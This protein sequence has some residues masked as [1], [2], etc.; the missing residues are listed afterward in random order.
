MKY[1]IDLVMWDLDGTLLDTKPGIIQA[2]KETLEL[3]ELRELTDEELETFIGPP[4]GQSFPRFYGDDKQEL[5]EFV[6]IFRYIYKNKTFYY[7]EPFDG[8]V[9]VMRTLRKNGIKQTL[10]TYKLQNYA[11][12]LMEH[13]KLDEFLN[14]IFG[15]LLTESLLKSDM[16]INSAK[17][18]HINDMKRTV[19]IGDTR[20][21]YSAAILANAN[22]IAANYGYGEKI[23]KEANYGG[24]LL[25]HANTAYEILDY[26]N[27]K[28]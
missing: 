1:D 8:I 27:I 24:T 17:Y 6:E 4:F 14:C 26:I 3:M 21:D 15:S 19:L 20:Y 11:M 12:D 25:G 10:C 2:I 22:F 16:L 13:Y 5:K 9:D 28:G 23:F 7:A 18:C